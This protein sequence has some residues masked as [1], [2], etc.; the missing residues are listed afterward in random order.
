M[1]KR[2]RCLK[3]ATQSPA[4]A[5]NKA[6]QHIQTLVGL[7]QKSIAE[8]PMKLAADALIVI[9]HSVPFR[10][11]IAQ[12]RQ[13]D[14]EFL[15]FQSRLNAAINLGK[16]HLRPIGEEEPG[17]TCNTR[18]NKLADVPRFDPQAVN[19]SLYIQGSN[20][21]LNLLFSTAGV[22]RQKHGEKCRDRGCPSS[23]CPD[24]IPPDHAVVYTQLLATKHPIQRA[25]S[26]IPLWTGQHSDMPQQRA[27]HAHG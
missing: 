12:L 24:C 4:S 21:L 13:D 18:L 22:V 11:A 14:Q 6:P 9:N 3:D 7:L 27:V 20:V 23:Y 1:A 17:L 25:H 8:L 2:S 26:L 10:K 19:R 15:R 5:L 16:P